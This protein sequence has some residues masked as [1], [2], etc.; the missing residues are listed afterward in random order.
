MKE[1]T[2]AHKACI[3]LVEN[4]VKTVKN[5]FSILMF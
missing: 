1:V 4:T 3:Y 2:Y 5:N